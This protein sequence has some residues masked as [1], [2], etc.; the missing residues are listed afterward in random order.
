MHDDGYLFPTPGHVLRGL[1]DRLDKSG[2]EWSEHEATADIMLAMDRDDVRPYRY[3]AERWGWSKSRVYR[4]MSDLKERAERWRTF[5]R[6]GRK[7]EPRERQRDSGGTKRDSD[8]TSAGQQ[9]DKDRPSSPQ[10]AETETPAGQVRDKCGTSAGQQRDSIEQ[11]TEQSTDTH[12]PGAGARGSVSERRR[13]SDRGSAF[14]RRLGVRA[15]LQRPPG[16]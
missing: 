10:E 12:T 4:H 7:T 6:S 11:S 1:L 5:N 9:R 3:Y 8:G 2:E 13:A 14:A 16:C 15:Q